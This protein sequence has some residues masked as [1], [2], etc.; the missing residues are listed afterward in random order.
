MF[1]TNN[2]WINLDA[3]KRVMDDKSLH[4]EIIVNPKVSFR[5]KNTT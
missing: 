2:L 4:M 3:M 1:N 5:K